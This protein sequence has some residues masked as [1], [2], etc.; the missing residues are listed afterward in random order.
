METDTRINTYVRCVAW[1]ITAGL[2]GKPWE[3]AV[4]RDKNPNAFALPGGKI[5]VHTGLLKVAR[6]QHQLAAVIGHEVGH[7]LANHANERVSQQLAVQG[8]LGAVGS[9]AGNVDPGTQQ[10]L[11]QGLGLGAQFGILLPFSRAQETEADIIGLD[12]MARAGYDP[13][14][15]LALWQNMAR[16]T[17]GQVP[18]FMSTHPSHGTRSR[19]LQEQMGRAMQTYQTARAQGRQPRCK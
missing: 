10:A 17:G 15:S 9:L 6:N 7:V 4:F 5:G 19:T 13:R 14:E 18:Q 1:D 3:V 12:L 11:L 16:A 2:G 8:G